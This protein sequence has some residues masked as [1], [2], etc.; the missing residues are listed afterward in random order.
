MNSDRLQVALIGAIG[1]ILD[2][3]LMYSEVYQRWDILTLTLRTD[4]LLSLLTVEGKS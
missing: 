4:V 2:C 3:Y 1:L